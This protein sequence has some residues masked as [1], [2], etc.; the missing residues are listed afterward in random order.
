MSGLTAPNPR[1]PIGQALIGNRLSL[2]LI[3]NLRHIPDM[4]QFLLPQ[5]LLERKYLHHILHI[6]TCFLLTFPLYL[7]LIIFF[8]SLSS[9]GISIKSPILSSFR[10]AATALAPSSSFSRPKI[11]IKYAAPVFPANS[12]KTILLVFPTALGGIGSYAAGFRNIAARCVPALCLYAEEPTIGFESYGLIEVYSSISLDKSS[13]ISNLISLWTCESSGTSIAFLTVLTKLYI[14]IGRIIPTVSGKLILSTHAS[15]I[16]LHTFNK[17]SGSALLP[18]ST[19]NLI[20][21]PCDF[22]Y[23][24][25]STALLKASSLVIRSL[26]FR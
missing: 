3:Q 6:L 15:S 23:S 16:A 12:P 18:S 7:S 13:S 2:L 8:S 10:P 14:P 17:N 20:F 25:V 9:S 26:S 19:V 5:H 24:T 21:S 11:D 1:Q 4:L 22:A